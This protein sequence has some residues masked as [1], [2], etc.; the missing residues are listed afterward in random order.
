MVRPALL[1]VATLSSFSTSTAASTASDLRQVQNVALP[2]APAT[3]A[4]ALAQ[5]EADMREDVET[6]AAGNKR[7]R[8]EGRPVAPWPDLS[9]YAPRAIQIA[10]D[11]P[12]SVTELAA[13]TDIMRMN[14]ERPLLRQAVDRVILGYG[15]DSRL[16]SYHWPLMNGIAEAYGEA[17]PERV[18]HLLTMISSP[19]IEGNVRLSFAGMYDDLEQAATTGEERAK[20]R[21]G[22]L[23][24][25]EALRTRLSKVP[26][27]MDWDADPLN[28][29]PDSQK[30]HLA[31]TVGEA[32]EAR[33]AAMTVLKTGSR[34]PDVQAD[35]YR[36]SIDSLANYRGKV[37]YLDFWATW[38]GP[39]KAAFPEN[40]KMVARL[41]GKPFA[42]IAVN[43]DSNKS[44]Y[45]RYIE[46]ESFPWVNWYSGPDGFVRQWGV[47]KYPTRLIIDKRGIVRG[48]NLSPKDA[49]KL[50]AS[51]IEEHPLSND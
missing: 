13:L 23:A 11:N 33:L 51:L 34:L 26:V 50:I 46:E 24:Q 37:V 27:V 39:C 35:R 40:R 10:N 1:I 7:A 43:A 28:R 45:I 48:Q 18:E 20:F 12:H 6:W 2:A 36:N 5:L 9:H 25:L 17:A 22:K 4:P 21:A 38:C 3:Y 44:D 8:A 29:G 14:A 42:F 47:S 41:K 32:A 49:D 31:N 19:I 30:S 15:S 16:L